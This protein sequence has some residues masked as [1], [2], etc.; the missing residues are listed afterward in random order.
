MT[1]TQIEIIENKLLN[2]AVDGDK[3]AARHYTDLLSP[4]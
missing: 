2:L 1:D 4:A 3:E